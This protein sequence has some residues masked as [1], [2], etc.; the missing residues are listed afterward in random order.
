MISC[1]L[2]SMLI[3]MIMWYAINYD[4]LVRLAACLCTTI[5]SLIIWYELEH[6]YVR[7]FGGCLSK[8]IEDVLMVCLGSCVCCMIRPGIAAMIMA[9]FSLCVWW[10]TFAPCLV[11]WF[12]AM[13]G[14]MHLMCSWAHVLCVCFGACFEICVVWIWVIYF[15]RCVL[16][17]IEKGRTCFE[18]HKSLGDFSSAYGS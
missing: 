4:W 5:G 8:A 1:L 17:M 14:D 9:L 13:L 7:Y 16:P 3:S 11:A 15:S 6:D 2:H 12:C 10:H 18:K